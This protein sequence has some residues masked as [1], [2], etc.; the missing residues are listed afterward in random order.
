MRN[1][2]SKLDIASNISVILVCTVF[3]SGI[4]INKIRAP[5]RPEPVPLLGTRPQ[6]SDVKWEESGKTVVLALSTTCG[7]CAASAKF[8][9]RLL[10]TTTRV[11]IPVIGVFPQSVDE[12]RRYLQALELP[13][14]DIRQLPGQSIHVT[15][16]PTLMIVDSRGIVTDAGV[17]LLSPSGE[18]E[19]LSKL[20][21]KGA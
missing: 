8:Y 5:R 4:V 3:I 9:S 20:N 1:I 7:Y 2:K 14:K 15:G 18:S 6:I 12:S 21:S 19:V 17:G 16:T 11:H 13:L 10:V